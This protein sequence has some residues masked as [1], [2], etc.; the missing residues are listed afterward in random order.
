MS[1]RARLALALGAVFAVAVALRAGPLHL[2][3]LP[4][5]PDGIVYAGHVRLARAT[6]HL[7]L[8]RMPVD[9]L[10]FTA[11]LTTMSAVTGQPALTIAQPAIAVVG[12][13]PVLVAAAAARRITRRRGAG[14]AVTASVLAGGLLAVSGLYLHRSMPVDEQTAGL[15]FVP[16]GVIAVARARHSGRTAWYV[17]AAVLA[18]ALPPTHN[19]DSVVFGVA[20]LA[21]VAIEV[22]RTPSWSRWLDAALAG[23]FWTVFAGY[24][25]LTERLTEAVIIQSSRVTE[26]LDLF[27]AWLL[28][29]VIATPVVLRARPRTQRIVSVG[30]FGVL[31]GLLTVNAVVP[32]FPGMPD[33]SRWV[34]VSLLPLAVP[35]LV[36]AWG[37]STVAADDREG[38]GLLALAAAVVLLL[39][40]SLSAALTPP[41]LNTIY[42]AQT[43]LHLPWAVLVA[44]GV[45]VDLRA[46]FPTR[47]PALR[48]AL[49]LVAAGLL[50]CAAVSVPLAFAGLESMPYKGITQEAELDATGHALEYAPTPWATDNH[51]SRIDGYYT[52][53]TAYRV[54]PVV[55]WLQGG[56]PPTC[57]VLSQRSWTTVGAQ[58][59]PKP[60]LAVSTRSYDAFLA[61]RQVVYASG[62]T[63]PIALS[64]PV[65]PR[66]T[67]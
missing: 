52:D 40:F 22:A 47:G 9:D 41:Y 48:T 20:L 16:L 38:R 6:G 4:F 39:G 26:A 54:A 29:L 28:L 44:V 57:S 10:H 31:F 23:G 67:C 18:V 43:F 64:L 42:R 61:Q 32:V 34:L 36:A 3:P 14:G 2:S 65:Q 62:A 30:G 8:F 17:V 60:P 53:E 12:A 51:L 5:N 21:W 27:V 66:E 58:L 50:C 24:Y 13:V 49:P 33:T 7:P 15:L 63:D 55:T 56:P 1:R 37:L 45:A 46:R 25:T 59:Y 35:S 11:L 19:L